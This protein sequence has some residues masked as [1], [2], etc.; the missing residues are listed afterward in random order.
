M[1]LIKGKYVA[2]LVFR[3]KAYYLG[4]YDSLEEASE[5][6]K[7]AEE[8]LFGATLA[9]Y[10][11]YEARADADPAWASANPVQIFVQKK[12]GHVTASFLPVLED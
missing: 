4:T 1:Y 2:K 8:E 12:D 3:K 9:Y 10:E 5:A 7:E 11:R 6:R